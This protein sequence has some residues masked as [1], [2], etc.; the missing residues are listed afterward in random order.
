MSTH[1]RLTPRRGFVAVL[2]G[3]A[4]ACGEGQT[5]TEPSLAKGG[6]AASLT[7]SPTSLVL[8]PVTGTPATLTAKVQFV[9][10]ITATS[11]D[12]GCA[13]VTP[14][15][16]P[17]TKP[18][19]SSV[20]VA[21]FTVTPVASGT[22]TITL[23][24]KK[25]EQVQAQVV[26]T[27]VELRAASLVAG[28]VHACALTTSGAAYCWGWNAFGQ[29]GAVLTTQ[30]TSS[31]V[32]VSGGLTFGSLTAGRYHT[33]GLT[34]SG[35]AYCWGDNGAGA[36]GNTSVSGTTTAPTAVGGGHTFYQLA[37]GG[38][39]TCGLTATGT[40]YCWGLN[41]H[42][43][44]GI[45]TNSGTNTANPTPA[46]VSGDLSFVA[47][48]PGFDHTCARTLEGAAYCWGNN[49]TGELGN[50]ATGTDPVTSPQAV[51]GDLA[52]TQL[53]AGN[54]FTCGLT[55]TG[56]AYCWG[57]NPNGELGSTVPG[58]VASSPA[59]V[60]GGLTF[61]SLA[62]GLDHTCA[63]T[64]AGAAYCW[65]RNPSGDLG[66]TPTGPTDFRDAPVAVG[67]GL[68]FAL[69]GAGEAHSCGL[70]GAGKAY[71]WGRN[72]AGE[73]GSDANVGTL[74]DNPSPVAVSGGLTFGVP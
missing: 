52:F 6:N 23:K 37:A 62:S 22:C 55:G 5:L 58:N 17:A 43:Q 72:E 53:S 29:V 24:D 50:G 70:T 48:T 67:G 33:C 4:L 46:A 31:P 68:T 35:A 73:L 16:A 14:A 34:R 38:L 2:A 60:S 8:S 12:A 10:T 63:L 66:V 30:Y 9:G 18:P 65:G 13:T 21:T 28:G 3:A 74:A 54:R 20:Y 64:G 19:G 36:L 69:L 56:A 26:V 1:A 7:V 49:G 42:G 41:N 51:A 59:A 39:H 71:C 27:A 15:S 57:F 44:L 40:A 32:A 61:A 11:S 45:T 25:G 47:I